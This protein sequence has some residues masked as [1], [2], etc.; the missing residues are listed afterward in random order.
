MFQT[1]KRFRITA[2]LSAMM[3]SVGML[4]VCP[5]SAAADNGSLLV[6]G[7]SIAV[8]YGLAET[9]KT[10]GDI[11]GTCMNYSVTNLAASGLDTTELLAQLETADTQA[12]VASA[13]LICISIGGNDLLDPT[14]DYMNSLCQ[15]GESM[16]D[17][18][19][20]LQAEGTLADAY[21]GLTSVLSEPSK[22][23]RTNIPL[24]ETAVRELNPDAKVVFQTIY[25]PVEYKTTIINGVDYSEEYKYLNNYASGQLKRINKVINELTQSTPA[26]VAGAIHYTAWIYLRTQEQDIHPSPLG[27]ALIAATIMDSIGGITGKDTQITKVLN[28][29]S[30]EDAATL[31]A[32]DRARMEAYAGE[33]VELTDSLGDVDNDA[34]ISATDATL[35]LQHYVTVTMLGQPDGILTADQALRADVNADGNVTSADATYILTYY[36][37]TML[38]FTP[39]WDDIISA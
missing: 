2:A 14:I 31:P 23:C 27:H 26:D 13:D 36:I 39:S 8:G 7:D 3:L 33:S 25:N 11:I 19:Q 5:L 1:T 18:V 17:M 21:T 30:A 38:G 28:A 35:A 20:R 15:E 29:L 24:I 9:D 22:T 16:L 12:A 10:Y 6:L 37:N 32:D 34:A 4:T